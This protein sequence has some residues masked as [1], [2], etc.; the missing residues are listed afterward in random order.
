MDLRKRGFMQKAAVKK[1]TKVR[2]GRRTADY[3]D[4]NLLA[5]VILLVCFGLVMLYS[6]SSYEA[7]LKF[8]GNDM[9]YFT[10]QAV[11]SAAAIL[12]AVLVSRLDYHL[13]IPVSGL[14]YVG[15]LVLMAMVKYTPLGVSAYGARR[16]LNLGIQ[17]QPSEVAKIAVIIYLPVVIIKM[18]RQFK[19]L[20]AVMVLLGL[21]ALQA[22]AA[23]VWTDNLSTGLIIGGIAVLM[24]FVAHP[25]TKWF[26]G[27][28]SVIAAVVGIAVAYMGMT[29][30][31]SDNF[32]IRRILSWLHPEE[33]MSGGGY[34]VMQS[35]YAIGSGGFFGKGLGN[36]AQKL[37]TIPEAQNDMIFSIV[38]EE[39]GVF[40]GVLLI[41]MFLYLLYRLF[42]IAQNAPDLYGTL[43]VSGIFAH[44]ALQVILNICVVINLMPTTGITLPFV[45]YGGTSIM[46]LMME[47]AIALSVSRRIRF[48]DMTE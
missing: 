48:K 46:F 9:Y 44:I 38:C 4:Y 17:F 35:L 36:S 10:R 42:F 3:Y 7:Q 39:L 30:T 27:V 15:S 33:N 14:A 25:D 22:V 16:W 37:G 45:S 13:L 24:I 19:T 5:A 23:L 11:I 18:G 12:L 47:I 6:T 8:E 26:V 32:R 20:K 31:T 43:V 2:T 41:L 29:M 21:G 1:K 34:Q 40:G 28:G